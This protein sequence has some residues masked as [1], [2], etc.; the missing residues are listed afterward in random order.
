MRA[1]PLVRQYNCPTNLCAI[2]PSL[3]PPY[4]RAATDFWPP[5]HW[6]DLLTAS[7]SGVSEVFSGI[8]LQMFTSSQIPHHTVVVG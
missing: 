8:R 2:R 5:F 1:A 6:A 4:R 3:V 7:R